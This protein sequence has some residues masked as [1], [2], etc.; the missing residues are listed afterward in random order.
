MNKKI[1]LRQKKTMQPTIKLHVQRLLL[2][3]DAIYDG[4]YI[5]GWHIPNLAKYMSDDCD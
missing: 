4:P 2:C 5:I 1:I 3:E